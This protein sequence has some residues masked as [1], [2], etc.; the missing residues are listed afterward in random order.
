MNEVS[1][2]VD[3]GPRGLETSFID[4]PAPT[5]KVVNLTRTRINYASVSAISLKSGVIDNKVGNLTILCRSRDKAT[6]HFS[7]RRTSSNAI[8]NGRVE[9]DRVLQRHYDTSSTGVLEYLK[10][11]TVPH[12]APSV[13]LFCASFSCTTARSKEP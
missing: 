3:P 13:P 1:R 6:L 2:P 9:K 5:H 4:I 11:G 8:P 10:R 7:P 12:G